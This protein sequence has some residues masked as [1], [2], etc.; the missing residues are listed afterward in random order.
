MSIALLLSTLEVENQISRRAIRIAPMRKGGGPESASTT[1]PTCH[2]GQWYRHLMRVPVGPETAMS[3]LAGA[4]TG[5]H[6]KYGG[7]RCALQ[8]RMSGCMLEGGRQSGNV[9]TS[10]SLDGHPS[11]PIPAHETTPARFATGFSDGLRSW[12]GGSPDEVPL[13]RQTAARVARV[14]KD[15]KHLCIFKQVP[16]A[17]PLAF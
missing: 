2:P 1:Q 8:W 6:S 10:L 15:Y 4:H 11:L 14:C 13:L 16:V 9:H 3:T 5:G 17:M 12:L 7:T